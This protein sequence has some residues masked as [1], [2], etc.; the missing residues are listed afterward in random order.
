MKGLPSL[1]VDL[2]K[3]LVLIL[4]EEDLHELVRISD[5]GDA[6]GALAFVSKTLAPKA[7]SALE[8]G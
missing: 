1:E 2:E 4:E 3:T 5:G 8:G 7:R 6:T